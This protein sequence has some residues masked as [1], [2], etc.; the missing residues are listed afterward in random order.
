MNVTPWD[1][2]CACSLHVCA[3]VPLARS[4]LVHSQAW[5]RADRVRGAMGA[6]LRLRSYMIAVAGAAPRMP[7][8]S[9]TQHCMHHAWSIIAQLLIGRLARAPPACSQ[10]W[11]VLSISTSSWKV[12]TMV[13]RRA[14]MDKPLDSVLLAVAPVRAGDPGG[15]GRGGSA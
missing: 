2:W 8:G 6:A 12:R 9:P 3:A 5:G 1:A 7:P 11:F 10:D 15:G 14:K 4:C 13:P